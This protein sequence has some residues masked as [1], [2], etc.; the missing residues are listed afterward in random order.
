MGDM[1]A[2][3]IYAEITALMIAAALAGGAVVGVI[4]ALVHF[5]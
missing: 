4:W 5:L 2:A 1:I 3:A